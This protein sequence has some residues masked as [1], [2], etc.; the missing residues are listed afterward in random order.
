[1]AGTP[2]RQSGPDR[3]LRTD[4]KK[5]ADGG[6]FGATHAEARVQPDLHRGDVSRLQT[7]RAV[8]DFE[9][10]ALVFLQRLEALGANFR[11]VR[12]QIV[13]AGVRLDETEA[14]G[15]VEPLYDTGLHGIAFQKK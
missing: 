4:E 10:H 8:L 5:P 11:E 1:M 2:Y 6:F 12:E 7:L 15:V 13:T 14:L 3:P 9:R